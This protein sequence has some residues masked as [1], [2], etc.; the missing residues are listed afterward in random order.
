MGN[1]S[2]RV[3]HFQSPHVVCPHICLLIWGMVKTTD[4]FNI[5]LLPC[6]LLVAVWSKFFQ[7][8]MLIM[9]GKVQISRN[10]VFSQ[11]SRN[12]TRGKAIEREER[13]T[14]TKSISHYQ[15]IFP[16]RLT[17]TLCL[18]PSGSL[19]LN[20]S[21]WQKFTSVIVSFQLK[22]QLIAE[23]EWYSNDIWNKLVLSI[24]SH[25]I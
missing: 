14:A 10:I 23:Y 1:V 13:I 9:R 11:D 16:H 6:S 18:S 3:P 20:A 21:D 17:N 24:A 5:F 15:T 19:E 25:A 8:L 4:H 7:M 2:G 12:W 22:T